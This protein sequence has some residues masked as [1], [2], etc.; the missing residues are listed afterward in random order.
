MKRRKVDSVAKVVPSHVLLLLLQ[1]I[2]LLRRRKLIVWAVVRNLTKFISREFVEIYALLKVDLLEDL[3]V[4][5]KF[6][7][8]VRNMVC[9]SSFWKCLP[10][11]MRNS[12]LT[13][14][15]KTLILAT[16]SMSVN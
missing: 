7:D 6:V 4:Y 12:L 13:A 3:D 5:A 11:Y 15:H 1:L 2:R 14:T 16:K 8:N 10:N 9:S